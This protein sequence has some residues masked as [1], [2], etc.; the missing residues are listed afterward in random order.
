[1]CHFNF[2][3]IWGFWELKMCSSSKLCYFSWEFWPKTPSL[4]TVT[5]LV[6]SHLIFF[7]LFPKLSLQFRLLSWFLH[8]PLNLVPWLSL[9]PVGLSHL[10]V[11]TCSP[12]PCTNKQV[13]E[14][15]SFSSILGLSKWHHHSASWSSQVILPFTKTNCYSIYFANISR[16]HP[17]SPCC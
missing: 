7:L 16:T 12:P 17:V 1:M 2:L 5:L 15:S 10:T 4:Q 14:S 6:F 11:T 8:C 9:R 13:S 3:K